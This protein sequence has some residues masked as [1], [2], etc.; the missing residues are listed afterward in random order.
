MNL[1][2][3]QF[4]VLQ[5][6]TQLETS[7]PEPAPDHTAQALAL[8]QFFDTLMKW[9]DER[10]LFMGGSLEVMVIYAPLRPMT[11]QQRRQLRQL[12]ESQLGV[13]R[14]QMK[15]VDLS[16]IHSLRVR[17]A[18]LE[19]FS[20][21]QHY[22]A[23]RMADCADALAGLDPSANRSWIASVGRH[24][25]SLALENESLQIW[26]SIARP[27]RTPVPEFSRF[28]RKTLELR[29]VDVFIPDWL[30][31]HWRRV[32]IERDLS[33]GQWVTECHG[34]QVN[35]YG[36]PTAQLTH[37]EVMLRLMGAVCAA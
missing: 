21:A 33:V 37:R 22:L 8:D 20:Q 11:R 26:L 3:L 23:G 31:L 34:W 18:C 6:H 14:C 24:G 7:P 13:A 25:A 1:Y 19:A 35:V 17:V 28:A 12:I 32:E 16:S 9:C 2:P 27:D 5:I 10:L 36:R 4:D 30:G 29:D 15:V